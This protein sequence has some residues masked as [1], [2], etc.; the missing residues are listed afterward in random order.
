MYEQKVQYVLPPS[1][2][3]ILNKKGTTNIQAINGT[4]LYYAQAV[5]PCMLLATNKIS[6]QQAQPTEEIINKITMLMDYFSTY[7]D[8]KVRYHASYMQ[9][10]IDSDAAY[11]VLPKA[12]SR[13]TGYFYLSEKLNNMHII[14][15]PKTNGPILEYYQT[16]KYAMSSAA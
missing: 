7:S 16:L 1:T 14:P 4:Y 8:D 15:T 12:R 13:G 9:L 3:P 10:Y 6:D 11:L 2:L 5:D